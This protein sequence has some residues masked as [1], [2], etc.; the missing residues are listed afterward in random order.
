MP[1]KKEGICDK[2]G[3][4]LV[5]RPDDQEEAIRNR[6]RVYQQQT[7][8][9]IDY[10]RSRKLLLEVPGELAIDAVQKRIEDA[11]AGLAKR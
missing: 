6:L 10:Y 3:S 4:R 8:P 2:C 5:Q 9:L 1:P 11:L 7:A